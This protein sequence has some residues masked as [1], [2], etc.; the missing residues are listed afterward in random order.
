MHRGLAP[1]VI[2]MINNPIVNKVGLSESSD[3]LIPARARDIRVEHCK[4]YSKL[5][6][7]DKS[8]H[9]YRICEP[10]DLTPWRITCS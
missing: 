7:S 4:S 6:Y 1:A 9:G 5:V 8:P 3:N 10:G 2:A